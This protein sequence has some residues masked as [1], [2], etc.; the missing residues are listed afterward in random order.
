MKAKQ[1]RSA[2]KFKEIYGPFPTRD[3]E[4]E[5]AFHFRAEMGLV[6]GLLRFLCMHRLSNI[7]TPTTAGKAG[8]CSWASGLTI[9]VIGYRSRMIGYRTRSQ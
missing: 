9:S 3:H 4:D 8:I 2:I 6:G 7:R 5:E 1:E